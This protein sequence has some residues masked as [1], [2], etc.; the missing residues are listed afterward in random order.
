MRVA[1]PT[2]T[3]FAD[4][5]EYELEVQEDSGKGVSYSKVESSIRKKENRRDSKHVSKTTTILLGTEKA[6]E[7]HDLASPPMPEA[8]AN[9]HGVMDRRTA[10]CPYCNNTDHY[11]NS[12]ASFK[13]LNREQKES[14]IRSNNRCWRCGR[15]HQA[16]KCTLKAPCKTCNRKHLLVLHEVNERG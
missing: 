12:C 11:L 2:L 5:L 10:Y 7:R 1:I 14:W 9:S 4:W 3:D 16:A 6:A 15:G 13:Q 8:P